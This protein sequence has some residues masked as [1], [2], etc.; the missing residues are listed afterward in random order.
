MEKEQV[1]IGA[2]VVTRSRNVT[3][4]MAEV[5]TPLRLFLGSDQ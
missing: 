5:V 2:N 1:K 4:H 3:F